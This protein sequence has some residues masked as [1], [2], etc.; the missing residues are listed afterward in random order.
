MSAST[1]TGPPAFAASPSANNGSQ[2]PLQQQKQTQKNTPGKQPQAQQ[3]QGQQNGQVIK[4]QP[5]GQPP[6]TMAKVQQLNIPQGTQPTPQQN[7][8]NGQQFGQGQSN[9]RPKNQTNGQVKTTYAKQRYD[10]SS[11]QPGRKPPQW[12]QH[13]ADFDTH[14]YQWNRTS[15]QRYHQ[16]YQRPQGWYPVHWVYGQVLPSLFWTQAYWLTAYYNF[17][18]MDPPYG[19]VWVQNG[20]DALLVNVQ[21]GQILSVEYNV[22]YS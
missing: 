18:L 16:G 11:Y 21:N 20:S 13:K 10:W 4:N 19:Y 2:L 7:L 22:F 17:G 15:N 1:M 3:L 14:A 5:A 8:K 12:Q 6:K 9:Q